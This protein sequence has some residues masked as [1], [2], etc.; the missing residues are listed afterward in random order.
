MELI[1][2]NPYFYHIEDKK[3]GKSNEKN[4]LNYCV[5]VFFVKLGG[6]N[7]ENHVLNE[8]S[9]MNDKENNSY[10]KFND[11]NYNRTVKMFHDTG[12]K[13]SFHS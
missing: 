13:N 1:Q 5:G 9:P 8:Q 10:E 12:Y 7:T 4:Q 6:V 3:S 11:N 2:K